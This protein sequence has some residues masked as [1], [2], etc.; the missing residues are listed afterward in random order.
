MVGPFGALLLIGPR[1][2]LFRRFGFL[3]SAAAIGTLLCA[4][5]LLPSYARIDYTAHAMWIREWKS[6]F[7]FGAPVCGGGCHQS[8]SLAILVAAGAVGLGVAAVR[9]EGLPF[10]IAA[11]G[12]LMALIAV[13]LPSS[14]IL[15]ARML[16]FY[17]AMVVLAGSY[18]IG[19]VTRM[20]VVYIGRTPSLLPAVAV[21][22]A[23]ALLVGANA[24]I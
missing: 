10:V 14:P 6:G 11:G 19:T 15:N 8:V 22:V 17:Y 24:E 3:A 18:G 9:R 12:A 1:R 20:M 23:G 2:S 16:P 7:L 21:E 4:F 5:W 13:R